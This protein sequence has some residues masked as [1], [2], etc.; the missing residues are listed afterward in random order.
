MNKLLIICGPTATGKT[1]LAVKLAKK[2]NGEI[3]SADSRQVYRGMD[4]GTG[5]DIPRNSKLRTPRPRRGEAE[6]GQNSKLPARRCYAS[7]VAGGQFKI[8]NYAIGY[9]FLDNIPIW[10]VDICQ[11]DQE[12]SVAHFVKFAKLVIEYIWQRNKLPIVVGGTGFWIKAL[13]SGVGSLGIPPNWKLRQQLNNETTEQLRKI[14]K[15][16]CPERLRGMNQSDKN[17]PRRLIRAIEITKTQNS[18]LKT[19]NH[20]LKVKADNL[21]I[22][23]LKTKN[24]QS[25]YQRIDRR[26]NRRIQ[27]GAEKEVKELLKKGYY[28]DLPSFSATGYRLWQEYFEGKK[29]LKDIVQRWKYDEHGLARRQLTFFKKDKRLDWFDIDKKSWYEKIEILVGQWYSKLDGKD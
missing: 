1:D 18:K 11:P 7:S 23:G 28:F 13:I 24:N 8:K 16:T 4:I 12:F 5:K 15:E 6:G 3:I 29:S 14:L 2:Y 22:I 17:N 21:L 10:L 19:Q 27:Q 9:R 26:V 20:N 25:L